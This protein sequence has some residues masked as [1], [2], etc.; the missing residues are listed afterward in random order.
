MDFPNRKPNRLPSFDY[1]TPGAYFITICIKGKKC[2]LGHIVGGG[3]FDAP[4]IKLS[5]AGKV[6]EKY[7][8]SGN[9]ISGVYVDK[10]VIMPNHIHMILFVNG[11]A[12]NGTSKAPSPTNAV[13]PHF[14]STF[15]R[16]CHRDLGETLF[17]RSYHDHII[18]G[19]EDYLKI[20]EYI[21]SNPAL[22][23]EDCFYEEEQP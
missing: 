21:D 12:S 6:V 23:K 13:I 22:W 4:Q 11:T 3:A 20:W 1:S 15:K 2:R 17:Q 9:C 14:V 7:I 18:R 19:D 5:T 10:Y 8:L 16:F